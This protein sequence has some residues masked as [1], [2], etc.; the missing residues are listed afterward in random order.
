[1]HRHSFLMLLCSEENG[2]T[3]PEGNGDTS[4]EGNSDTSPE[5]NSDTSPEG[6]GDT[7]P[8]NVKRKVEGNEKTGWYFCE[9]RPSMK[10]S[11]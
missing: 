1:M 10:G 2:D 11:S 8:A 7:N 3:S 5:G 4:P 9:E 6:N